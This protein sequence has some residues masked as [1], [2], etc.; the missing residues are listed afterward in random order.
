M[1]KVSGGW[2]VGTRKGAR[3]GLVSYHAGHIHGIRHWSHPITLSLTGSYCI[4]YE[5][6]LFV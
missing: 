3:D 2:E 5:F 1:G 4:Q 6:C